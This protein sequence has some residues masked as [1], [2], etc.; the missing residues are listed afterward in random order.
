MTKNTFFVLTAALSL[1]TPYMAST[2]S[3][4]STQ[5]H[6][7]SVTAIEP[8]AEQSFFSAGDD[9][10]LVKWDAHGQ[11][12]HYQLSDLPIN[13]I[14]KNPLNS[15]LAVAESDNM[16]INRISV[17]DWESLNRRFAKRFKNKVTC[18]SYSANGSF[19]IVGTADINGIFILDAKTGV[20]RKNIKE[21][22]GI[23]TLAKTGA[24]E[25]TAVMY[26]PSGT[27]YY[28]D[29]TKNKIKAKFSTENALEQ[30]CLFGSGKF[31]N[32][33]F[34]GVKDNTIYVID[35]TT[36]SSLA[37]YNATNPMIVSGNS[38]YEEGLFYISNVGRN[39]ALSLISNESLEN[40]L[41]NNS[42]T[43]LK[44]KIPESQL[45]KNFMG[46]KSGDKFTCIEKN[47]ESIILGTKNGDIYTMSDIKESETYSLEPIT[48]NNFK[49]I[50]DVCTDGHSVFFL[51]ADKIYKTDADDTAANEITAN[52]GN[53]SNIISYGDSFLLWSKNSKKAVKLIN[54]TDRTSETLFAPKRK[55]LNVRLAE[56]KESIICI[57]GNNVVN[58]Y[59][60]ALGK[61]E[62]LYSGM[63][64]EDAVV[65]GDELF[66]AK[67]TINENDS[68][69]IMVN[70]KTKETVP[71]KIS[72]AV[73]YSLSYAGGDKL[74]GVSMD[75]QNGNKSQTQIFSYNINTK[76]IHSIL[77][78]NDEDPGAF[79]ALDD[80]ILYSN[81][82]KNQLYTYS[83]K[84]NRNSSYQR[85]YSLPIKAVS[86]A[87]YFITLNKDGSI[88]WYDPQSR[89]AVKSCYLAENNEWLEF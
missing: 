44:G 31:Q 1:F 43:N 39:Y 33:F 54:L 57:E 52:E 35:A 51:T 84:E 11:G 38:G 46:L 55:L 6:D 22:P 88:S 59:N 28:W 62:V 12:S 15:E 17:Y 23:I 3:Y 70:T 79:T 74:Y 30:P 40:F 42:H 72:S 78:L 36:G 77:R 53:E 13:G 66:I 85:S 24:S 25:K 56:D 86:A 9:G 89:V 18:L 19:L 65:S 76:Y 8:T 60:I 5:S 34:A 61:N 49:K 50:S 83:I 48:Q 21:I 69:L 58:L 41:N 29:V 81:I 27:L 7:G 71:L 75:R 2:Q 37:L 73:T 16:S 32:R 10:F 4:I 87:G 45:V 14:S 67:S 82:G 64:I 20:I 26:S 47:Q 68:P 80:D 63:A